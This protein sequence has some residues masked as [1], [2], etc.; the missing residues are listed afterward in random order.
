MD[1]QDIL[2]RL[3]AIERV[4]IEAGMAER[5]PYMDEIRAVEA[6]GGQDTPF[7]EAWIIAQDRLRM[8]NEEKQSGR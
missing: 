4:L 1:I 8:L 7:S 5:T 6:P 3:D 2:Y